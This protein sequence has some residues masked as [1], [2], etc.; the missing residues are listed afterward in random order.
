MQMKPAITRNNVKKP[1][2]PVVFLVQPLRLQYSNKFDRIQV[3]HNIGARIY[4]VKYKIVYTHLDKH[5]R[6][7][8][9]LIAADYEFCPHIFSDIAC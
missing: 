4:I 2:F 5:T 9:I 3:A 7:V 6:S 1:Q 8:G